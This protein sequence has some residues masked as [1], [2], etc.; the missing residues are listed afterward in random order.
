MKI[1]PNQLDTLELTCKRCKQTKTANEMKLHYRKNGDLFVE[2]KCKACINEL[3]RE[4]N[5]CVHGSRHT[6]YALD[7]L[8]AKELEK[9]AEVQARLKRIKEAGFSLNREEDCAKIVAWEREQNGI[10]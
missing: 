8:K 3:A 4:R 5:K 9:R 2:L 6:Q 7:W 1:K 10:L